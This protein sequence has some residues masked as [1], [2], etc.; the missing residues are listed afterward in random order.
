MFLEACHL[1]GHALVLVRLLEAVGAAVWRVQ[2][3][4]VEVPASLAGGLAVAFYLPSFAFVAGRGVVA[5][6][7]QAL[8]EVRESSLRPSLWLREKNTMVIAEWGMHLTMQL[9]CTVLGR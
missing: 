7:V 4:E 5:V 8:M 3:R 2:A 9:K 6:S 1:G